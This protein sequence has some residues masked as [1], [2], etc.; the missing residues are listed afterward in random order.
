[1]RF[2]GNCGTKLRNTA[3]LVQDSSE[4]GSSLKLKP[5][6]MIGADLGDRF[7]QAGLEAAGQR[8]N[9]TVL[10]AD[11]YGYTSMSGQLDPETVFDVIQ[12]FI[13]LL[14]NDVYRYEGIVDKLTGDGLMALFGAPIAHE[15]NA[16][17]AVRAAVE[18]QMDVAKLSQE[19]EKQ[20]GFKLDMRLGL[21]SGGVIVGGIGTNL[22]MDYTA[23]G[24][25]VN[26]AN[27]IEEAADP[28]SILVSET[29]YRQTKP[30]FDYQTIQKLIL[31]G[32][33]DPVT[34]YRFLKT[35][36]RPDS[37][38]GIEGIR[39]SLVGRE[40]ELDQLIKLVNDLVNGGQGRFVFLTGE[41]GIGKSRLIGELASRVDL[42]EAQILRGQS[43][44]YRKSVS[45][46]IFRDVLRSYLD[47]P[48]GAS[49]DEVKRRLDRK[50]S[51]ALGPGAS[52]A[53]PY[54]QRLMSLGASNPI[55]AER[56]KYLD[57]GV[58]RQ[59]VFL[60]VRDLLVAEAYRK[61]MVLILED[62]HWAD[63][64]SLELLSF[65]MGSI[66]QAPMLMLAISRPFQDG[67]LKRI[68]EQ[69]KIRLP[70]RYLSLRLNSLSYDQTQ[71]LLDELLSV[72]EIPDD[73]R[74]QIL[75][76]S[77]GVP[78]YLEEILRNLI[79]NQV[80]ESKNGQWRFTSEISSANL[81]VPDSLEGL[82]LARFDRLDEFSRHLL[83]VASVI[84]KKFDLPLLAHLVKTVDQSKIEASLAAMVKR[85]FLVEHSQIPNQA[86]EFRHG[87]MSEAIYSTLLRRE[88]ARLH[89]EVGHAI[90]HIH[91]DRL[92]EQVELLARHYSWSPYRDK[93]FQYLILSGQKA[94]NSYINQQA[95]DN[96]EQ[97]LDLLGSVD[98]TSQ[99]VVTLYSGL[100]D[101]LALIGNYQ[102][103]H[104][105][106]QS[107]IDHLEASTQGWA[108][109]E[110]SSLYRKIAKI[111]ER[112]GEYRQALDYL[113]TAHRE[114]SQEPQ[115]QPTERSQILNDIG[116]IHYRQGNFPD[117]EELFLQALDLVEGQESYDVVASIYNRLGG[118]AYSQG[119]WSRTASYL[120][121]SIAI[122]ESIG[123]VVG[124]ATSFNNLGLLGIEM[125]EFDNALENLNHSYELKTR[126]GQAEGIAMTLN[127]LGWLQIQKGELEKARDSLEQALSLSQRIGYSSLA[128]YALKNLGEL[129][130]ATENYEHAI[131]AFSNSTQILSE[132]ETHDQRID[133]YRLLG[134]AA[135]GQKDISTA[136]DW[137]HKAQTILKKTGSP[138]SDL[139]AVQ[140]GELYR[141]R[142]MLAYHQED[143]KKSHKFLKESERI[144]KALGSGFYQGRVAYQFGR[145]AELRGDSRRAVLHY[146]VAILLFQ[147]VGAKL[148]ENRAE[149][150]RSQIHQLEDPQ[151]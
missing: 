57:A 107:A 3:E 105:H 92:H 143:W 39:A 73:Y 95:R 18:M 123:D 22:L 60:A 6:A 68:A 106:Y 126:L 7:R 88:R 78:F 62:L 127:N 122:R 144:F 9:V 119:N 48:A 98:P 43:L 135:L 13:S 139:T 11:L 74:E 30:L 16:E 94:A 52:E 111:C 128:A 104:K 115:H 147:S 112:Q 81:G 32:V 12:N 56:I 129:H 100:G 133:N 120:R 91:S 142:G 110:L 70:D 51:Q 47:I 77:A 67:P 20:F 1:M 63:E 55:A 136:Q 103:A 84:G 108:H 65:V 150:A 59:Q 37:V 41:A 80:I 141:F 42:E 140:R 96:F 50:A 145:L 83:Q 33:A 25:T 15:N 53:L 134:E 72:P 44:T 102:Q 116:W 24:D 31:K 113:E 36:E 27:R 19:V 14:I 89:G 131:Q 54:L 93:A 99:Q 29:V 64:A 125:G 82:I 26:L 101:L 35:K 79:D 86:Y 66:R 61:P 2:C 114:L 87:L 28:G 71:Y 75:Q 138:A 85:E 38:R 109:R 146:R 97:A 117:A 130:L 69:G 132:L 4:S 34:A 121:K 118:I 58:L 46:W 124:L 90:E 151:Q 17:R 21:H 149:K 8:R 76:K 49:E 137:E 10:F 40:Q 148:E 23:I 5:G 45:Y